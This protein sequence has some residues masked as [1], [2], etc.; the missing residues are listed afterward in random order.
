MNIAVVGCGAIAKTRHAPGVAEHP[1]AVLY[2]VCDPVR[3][4]ADALAEAYHTK[5]A[6]KIED[7]LGDPKVDAVIICTPERFHCANVVAA[8]EA[9]KDVLCEKPLAMTPLE[10]RAILD[11]QKASGRLLMVA[12]GQRL[13]P[14]HQLAKR[15]LEEGAIGKPLAFRTALAHAGVEYATIEGPSPDFY[16]KKLAGIGDVMLS[17]GCHRMDLMPYLLG[18]KIKAV[19]ALL[20]TIDKTYADGRPIDAA[21]HAMIT[22]ELDNGISGM[23]WISWCDYG[24]PERSTVIYGTQ[25]VMTVCR[26]PE[27]TV[28]R[29]DRRTERYDV[30]SSTGEWQL[31]TRHFI[32]V[33]AGDALPICSGSDGQDCLLALEAA[34]RSHQQG[35]RV[36]LAELSG[37]DRKLSTGQ[38]GKE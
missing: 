3:E 30:A 28:E 24:Q 15:L 6:Y 20:P 38:F 18:G 19:S 34:K 26:S 27:V 5:A 21:D 31:P 37:L 29:R 16:D 9:G 13:S 8:L 7:V 12:F 4:N 2:A 11:A 14:G 1:K 25:G 23:A 22:M 36:E 10:G 32:D 33:L 35:R 17:V